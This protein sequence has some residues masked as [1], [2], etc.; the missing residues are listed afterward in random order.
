MV[1]AGTAQLEGHYKQVE[2]CFE[3][4]IQRAVKWLL[5]AFAVISLGGAGAALYLLF[6]D[7][8]VVRG[9]DNGVDAILENQKAILDGQKRMLEAQQK[10]FHACVKEN[11]D[12]AGNKP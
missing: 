6:W 8:V 5:T 7:T 2:R 12:D 11:A 10:L 1:A 4:N 3:M 9:T